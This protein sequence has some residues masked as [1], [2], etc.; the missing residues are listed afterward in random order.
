MSPVLHDSTDALPELGAALQVPGK[1]LQVV[2]VL[3]VAVAD[4]VVNV[5]VV[6]KADAVVTLPV[7]AEAHCGRVPLVG[8]DHEVS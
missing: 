7:A 5:G 1:T 6:G 2:V 3:V 8:F 4:V